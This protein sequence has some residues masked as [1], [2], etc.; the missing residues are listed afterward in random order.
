MHRDEI[1]ASVGDR[2]GHRSVGKTTRHIV[3]DHRTRLDR[4][5]RDIRVHR[6]DRH[7]N[8]LAR[9]RRDYRD[10]TASLFVRSHGLGSG[11]GRFAA[12]VNDVGTRAGETKT[13]LDRSV[14]RKVA[15][16]VTK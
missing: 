2:G 9:E 8:A 14:G 10:D 3:N 1:N 7:R 5:P 4:R 6:V 13:V 15:A 12:H 11:T 16:A